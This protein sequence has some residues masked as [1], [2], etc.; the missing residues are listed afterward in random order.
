MDKQALSDAI[1]QS[2]GQQNALDEA[3]ALWSKID[4]LQQTGRFGPLLSQLEKANEKS[5]FLALVLEVSFAYQFEVQGLELIY[6]VKQNSQQKSS[7]DFLHNTTSGDSVFFEVR[8]LQQ[9][10]PITDWV[11]KQL[12]K[13][14]AYFV[15]MDGQHEQGEVLRIQNTILIKVQDKHGKP[16]KFFSTTSKAVNIVAIDVTDS[17]LGAIDVHDCKL[18]TYGDPG[19]QEIYRRGVFG[20]FQEDN[21]GYPQ[22]FHDLAAKYAYIRTTLHGV[23]FLFK[24]FN[25]G[26]L[27]YQLEQYLMWNPMCIDRA[28]SQPIFAGITRAIPCHSPQ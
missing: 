28:R 20:L 4:Y 1:R 17:I 24:K 23:L 11:Y 26:I 22:N 21:P 6:E 9:A 7:I 3:D 27:T 13:L 25:T 18:A 19:V 16:V 14:K 15:V 10:K 12:K 2:G 8:L 5:N